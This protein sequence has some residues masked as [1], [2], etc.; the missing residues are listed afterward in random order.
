MRNRKVAHISAY[1][2]LIDQLKKYQSKL[3]D[4]IVRLSYETDEWLGT[5]IYQLQ[6]MMNQEKIQKE[7]MKK[8]PKI[9]WN[10]TNFWCFFHIFRNFLSILYD[11]L[12]RFFYI[13]LK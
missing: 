10:F 5:K 7:K 4:K 8:S 1:N 11:F 6:K 9:Y 12:N 2:P 13:F 3:E